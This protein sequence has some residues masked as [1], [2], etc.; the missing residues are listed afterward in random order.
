[1]SNVYRPSK[2]GRSPVVSIIGAVF[3]TLLMFMFLAFTQKKTPV[4]KLEKRPTKLSTTSL[5]SPLRTEDPPSQSDASPGSDKPTISKN[6]LPPLPLPPVDYSGSVGSV[7]V[8]GGIQPII[9]R[10]D[11]GSTLAP[12]FEPQEVD[13]MVELRFHPDAPIYPTALRRER[14]VGKADM[15]FVVNA[16]GSIG[17][18]IEVENVNNAEFIQPFLT[19]I[20]QFKYKPA[21]KNGVPVAQRVRQPVQLGPPTR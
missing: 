11:G 12:I 1:M 19:W 9:W 14:L 20:R 5:P 15:V 16:D 7:P 8:P 10:P 13:T 21:I 2:T 17:S 6:P 18:D 4:A 3:L